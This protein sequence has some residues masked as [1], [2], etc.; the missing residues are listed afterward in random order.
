MTNDYSYYAKMCASTT[1]T[2]SPYT[3]TSYFRTYYVHDD[4]I[5]KKK[6]ELRKREKRIAEK[7]AQLKLLENPDKFGNVPRMLEL[8]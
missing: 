5:E 3:D 4:S 8:D 7:E 6:E 1:S 2:D